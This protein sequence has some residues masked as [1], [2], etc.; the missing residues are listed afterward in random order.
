MAVSPYDLTL[1][2]DYWTYGMS[3]VHGFSCLVLIITADIITAILP[4]QDMQEIPQGFTQVGHV[5][6]YLP[7]GV[8]T[9]N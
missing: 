1:D 6:M 3:H 4:E 8:R 9:I 7:G 5:C 2:Y